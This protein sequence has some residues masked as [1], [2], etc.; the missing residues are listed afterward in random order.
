MAEF[1]F[2]RSGCE[3]CGVGSHKE[4]KPGRAG[5]DCVTLSGHRHCMVRTIPNGVMGTTVLATERMMA[6][7]PISGVISEEG[8]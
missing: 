5:Q 6:S 2:A 3:L 4:R 7:N 1:S 8:V